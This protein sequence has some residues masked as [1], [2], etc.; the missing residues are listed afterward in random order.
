LNPRDYLCILHA[1]VITRTN[2]PHNSNLSKLLMR[3]R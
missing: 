3:G 1:H 2:K